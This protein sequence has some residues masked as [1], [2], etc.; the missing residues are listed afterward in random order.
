MKR[1]TKRSYRQ[2]CGLARGLD[3][4][5]ERWTLLIVRNLL[6]GP[7]R[8]SDLLAELPGIT[9]NLLAQRLRE[10]ESLGIV[11]RVEKPPPVAATVYE[12][13]ELGGALEPAIMELARWGSRFLSRPAP[14]ETVNVGWGL[15]SL[16]RRYRGS[17][18]GLVAE[19]RIDERRFELGLEP[20]Y[21]RVTERA[22]ARP[23]VVVEGARQT[24][25]DLLFGGVSAGKLIDQG[26]LSVSD[27]ERFDQLIAA[28]E[29][30]VA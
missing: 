28:F 11:Q 10:M 1:R 24:V 5:G 7:R 6:L 14:G 19:L 17:A 4:V 2:F 23:D 13:T 26:A 30:V 22:C 15:L 9:T 25:R 29:G 21:L 18:C 20:K 16:K 8:Y 12:L 3:L 27:R